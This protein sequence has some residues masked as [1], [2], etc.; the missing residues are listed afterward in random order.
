MP[1]REGDIAVVQIGSAYVRLDLQSRI[2]LTQIVLDG[3]EEEALSYLVERI[4]PVLK[5]AALD[6]RGPLPEWEELET[7]VAQGDSAQALRY[8]AER[9][10]A[11]V[12]HF[13]KRPGCRPMFE[14]PLGK[15]EESST[16]GGE[17]C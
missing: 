7:I 3:R 8:L 1:F 4:C 13:M 15:P 11:A 6:T 10:Y 5:K 2:E 14:L 9:V 17:S 16:G 12:N